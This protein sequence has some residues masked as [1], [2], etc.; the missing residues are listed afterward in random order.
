MSARSDR[1]ERVKSLVE[2]GWGVGGGTPTAPIICNVTV[3][4]ESSPASSGRMLTFLRWLTK[5]KT[6]K[7]IYQQ[8]V[9]QMSP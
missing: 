1:N 5:R 6:H 7:I 4:E 3:E 8:N 9:R 2:G